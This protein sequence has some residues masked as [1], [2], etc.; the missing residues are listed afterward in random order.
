MINPL[1]I[2]YGTLTKH[3]DV[4]KLAKARFIATNTNTLTIPHVRNFNDY[5]GDPCCGTVKYLIVIYCFKM[6][7]IP[8]NNNDYVINLNTMFKNNVVYYIC[9]Y[10][11]YNC[12]E[13]YVDSLNIVN[14][15]IFY[16]DVKHLE[17]LDMTNKKH[18]YIFRY[19]VIPSISPASNIYLLN[20]EQLTEQ[21]VYNK[22]INYLDYQIIDYSTVNIKILNK[23]IYLP[24]QIQDCENTKLKEFS[25]NPIYDIAV[26]GDLTPR[27]LH[28]INQLKTKYKILIVKGWNDVRDQQIGQCKILLNI[29]GNLT[30]NRKNFKIFEHMRCDRWIFAGKTIISEVSYCME[31]LD[32]YPNVVWCNYDNIIENVN[33]T[34]TNNININC[35]LPSIVAQRTDYLNKFIDMID[36]SDIKIVDAFIF[37]N[38]LDILNYRLATL[39][40]YVDYFVIIESKYT[41][42][43]K[44]KPLFYKNHM[45][46]FKPYHNKIIHI[47]LDTAPYIYPN[48]NY[49]TKQQ[50][51]N[52]AYQRN[53]I[54]LGIDQLKLSD[55]DF[56]IISDVD[57]IIDY[58]ILTAIKNRILEISIASLEQDFYYYNLNSKI[59][60]IW[61]KSKLISYH[62]FQTL[63]I[64]C[65]EIRSFKNVT[66]I[67]NAGWH[68]SYFGD[69]YFI[70]NKIQNFSHQEY[71]NSTYTDLTAIET[72]MIK[73][74]DMF[75]RPSQPITKISIKDNSYLPPQY[76]QYLTKFYSY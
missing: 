2:L 15:K 11:G 69:K 41:F 22:L 19:H 14:V 76:D 60:E 42:S 39:Y 20:T 25:K 28:I 24:Y 13:D 71:N 48:I 10:D 43:G 52:E 56:I 68:L 4:T 74:R 18:I 34:I 50:W 73:Q 47:V 72:N 51:E 16:H 6:I 40:P 54:K 58:H 27:R 31:E 21:F 64:S 44:E 37:Y 55:R 32:I 70:Q 8:E 33:S 36:N 38:E 1:T 29:H 17:Y 35:P 45:D 23:G 49:S 61:C 66:C 75:N 46:D 53:A 7:V 62:M 59:K 3:I 67:K 57:E 30:D 12:F 5:F 9:E 63:N 26:V 65:E